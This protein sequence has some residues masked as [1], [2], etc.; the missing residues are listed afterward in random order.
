MSRP[1]HGWRKLARGVW[2]PP[3]DPQFYGDLEI[4]AANL[5]AYAARVEERTG[6]HVTVTH[7]IGK[8]VAHGL[9]RVPVLQVR[10]AHGREYPRPTTDVFFIVADPTTD[11]LTGTKVES[12]DRKPVAQIAR[13]LSGAAHAIADGSDTSFGRAKHTMAMLPF[14]AVGPAVRFSAW[15]ASDLD[16]DLPFLGVR[17]QPFGSAMISSVGMWGVAKAYSPLASYYRVPVLVLVGAVTPRPVAIEG[18]VVVRP[19]LTVTATFD[20]RYVDGQQA[21]ALAHAVQEYCAAPERFEAETRTD[22]TGR[23]STDVRRSG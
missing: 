5:L 16:L 1:V 7:L 23:G 4:D 13:E 10:V 3:N 8:A 2:G 9:T 12:A 19:M 18:R 15:L 22:D 14:W 21:A 20:H 6:V 11:E 17:R